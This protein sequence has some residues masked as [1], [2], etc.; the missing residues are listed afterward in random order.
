MH[1]SS[2][3]IIKKK[4][5]KCRPTNPVIFSYV[6]GNKQFVYLPN[7]D[8]AK[9]IS[10]LSFQTSSDTTDGASC[11]LSMGMHVE[12]LYAN[13]GALAN[14]QAKIIGVA[15]KYEDLQD[16]TYTVSKGG[17]HLPPFLIISLSSN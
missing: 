13:V 9:S 10:P 6:T 1:Y 4:E 15:F 2:K 12:I 17:H 8:A 16:V 3:K 11:S 7:D 5:K 14:P